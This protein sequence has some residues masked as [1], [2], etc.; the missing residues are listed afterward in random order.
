[1]LIRVWPK[2]VP[3][4]KSAGEKLMR[5]DASM[6][7]ETPGVKSFTPVKQGDKVIGYENVTIRGYLSTFMGTTPADRDG[8]AVMPGAFKDSIPKFMQNPVLLCDHRN[9]VACL[10][11]SFTTVREDEKGLYVEAVLSNSPSD[12]AEDIRWK[13]AEGHLRTLSMG[14]LFHYEADGRTIFRVDLFEGSLVAI[15]AN[16]DAL[17]STRCLTEEEKQK[18]QR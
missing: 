12:E 8:D 15:P 6:S 17:I 3:P 14:G 10:A 1:M 13:V 2:E 16:P 9:S 5:F 11:G 18:V 7:L 4:A